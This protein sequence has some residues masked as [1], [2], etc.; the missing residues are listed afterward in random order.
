MA[1][2]NMQSAEHQ[3][4]GE[5]TALLSAV[6]IEP[7]KSQTQ[8]SGFNFI[9]RCMHAIGTSQRIAKRAAN[10]SYVSYTAGPYTL[11]ILCIAPSP[12]STQCVHVNVLLLLEVRCT[13]YYTM[14][15]PHSTDTDSQSRVEEHCT[16]T[17]CHF[18]ALVCYAL[19][20]LLSL[21][22][23]KCC[24]RNTISLPIKCTAH[25]TGFCVKPSS[26]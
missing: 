5:L 22:L 10:S 13:C 21:Q 6:E 8:N 23:I 25:T 7:L 19:L 12:P 17:T 26:T 9:L 15:Q 24:S 16:A 20:L 1:V 2:N 11:I 3:A 4:L 18:V 14:V